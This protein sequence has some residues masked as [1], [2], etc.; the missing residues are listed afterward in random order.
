MR[1]IL[2]PVF[3]LPLVLGN[4]GCQTP[5]KIEN[6]ETLWSAYYAAEESGDNATADRL[7]DRLEAAVAAAASDG[8]PTVEPIRIHFARASLRQGQARLE[9]AE[10]LYRKTL[11]EIADVTAQSRP[12]GS[13]SKLLAQTKVLSLTELGRIHVAR[14]EWNQ[15]L[16]QL[17]ES[18]DIARQ[19]DDPLLAVLP[20]HELAILRFGLG[21]YPQSEAA[22]REALDRHSKSRNATPLDRFELLATYA[23]LLQKTGRATEADEITRQAEDLIR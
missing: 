5:P 12:T 19:E 15:A 10:H 21:Q 14:D 2:F 23:V 8:H 6:P 4:A 11:R 13:L 9:D 7:L 18:V 22:I 16:K 1:W 17:E 20:L 3:L